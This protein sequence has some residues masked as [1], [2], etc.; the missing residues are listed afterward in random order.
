MK[1]LAE[2]REKSPTVHDILGG[3]GYIFGLVSADK[4]EE[5]FEQSELFIDEYVL[6][7]AEPDELIARLFVLDRYLRILAKVRSN[8]EIIEPIR[9]IV[10]G[11]FSQSTITDLLLSEIGRANRTKRS[12]VSGL[13]VLDDADADLG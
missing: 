7:P 13:I 12:F 5:I 2:C 1:L 8:R 11:V 10:T 6:K 3:I 9:D 4:Q